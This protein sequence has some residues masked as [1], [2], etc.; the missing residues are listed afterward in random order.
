MP[1]VGVAQATDGCG[2]YTDSDSEV[3]KLVAN[4]PFYAFATI[5]KK[6]L[7]KLL[8]KKCNYF[9]ELWHQS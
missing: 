8:K 9:L 5:P 7:T 2:A 6:V 4:N 1:N 3:K